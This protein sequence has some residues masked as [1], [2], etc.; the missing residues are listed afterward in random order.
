MLSKSSLILLASISSSAIPQAPIRAWFLRPAPSKLDNPMKG[1]VPYQGKPDTDF[2]HSMEFNY[3]PLNALVKGKDVYDWKALEDLLND[4]WNRNHQTVFRIYLEYPK[5][6]SGIPQFLIDGGLKVT[7]WNSDSKSSDPLMGLGD[8]ATP[9]YSDPKL[10]RC[11][12]SFITE[13]G[14]KYDGD[15]R[16]A[17]ITMGL[18]G[19]WGEWHTWPKDELFAKPEVQKEVMDSFEDS[20]KKTP[21]LMRYPHK[22]GDQG[23]SS[24]VKRSFGF[25]DDSFAWATLDTGKKDENWFFLAAMKHAGALEKWRSAPIGGEIRPEAWGHCFDEPIKKEKV[26]DFEKCVRQTHVTWLMDSGMFS[27][28]QKPTEKRMFR[29]KE[30]VR[31]MGYDFTVYR[32]NFGDKESVEIGFRN[33]GVA[34]FYADWALRVALLENGRLTVIKTFPGFFKLRPTREDFS[35]TLNLP[36]P[37]AKASKLLI[38]CFDPS[39]K[40]SVGFAN[41]GQDADVKGWLTLGDLDYRNVK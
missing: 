20:F 4:V 36:S 2:P 40:L 31:M 8:Q 5:K 15:P 21:I 27:K 32:V 6:A 26:Q 22:E 34:P 35:A 38:S 9:D 14:K 10:R 16:V 7:V 13:L 11:L 24:N 23:F 12:K 3:L 41:E 17:F 1:L 25:H 30:M 19:S 29:A 33:Q 39:G 28:E 18:L 37:P